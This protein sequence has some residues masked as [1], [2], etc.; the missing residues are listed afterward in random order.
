MDL[1]MRLI[2]L[3]GLLFFALFARVSANFVFP[4]E[5][6]F[7]GKD[8]SLGALKAHDARRH[9]RILS[10]VDLELG[11]NGLPSE[12]GYAFSLFFQ[13][14]FIFFFMNF[15]FGYQYDE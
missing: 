12:T 2:L 5:H 7:K 11:G 4:I 3:G 14:R 8:R 13:F 15:R 10:A 6:K 9:R 1:R